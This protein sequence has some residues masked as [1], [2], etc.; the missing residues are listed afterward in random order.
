ME[1]TLENLRRY[2]VEEFYSSRNP[3]VQA[4]R[5]MTDEINKVI[6]TTRIK[7]VYPKNLFIENKQIELYLF[8]DREH[9]FKV[10]HENNEVCIFLYFLKDIIHIKNSVNFGNKSRTLT[11][12][13][14]NGEIFEFN[15]TSD[16]N[17]H[18]MHRFDNLI[19][20]IWKLPL[21]YEMRD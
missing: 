12:E 7:V 10:T 14:S 13:F 17:S 2:S 5:Y 3:Q 4:L 1:I 18:Y 19:V 16:T 9:I 11:I 8:D 21:R 20:D 6:D 15:N